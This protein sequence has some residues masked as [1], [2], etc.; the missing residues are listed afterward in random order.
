MRDRDQRR[1]QGTPHGFDA[2]SGIA[3]RKRTNPSRD[4]SI[5]HRT[6]H[7]R[8]IVLGLNIHKK[9]A[10]IPAPARPLPAF[11]GKFWRLQEKNIKC[12]VSEK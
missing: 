9:K 8:F 11:I 2:Q 10:K 6:R 5:S 12:G 4:I 7:S 1:D 3:I